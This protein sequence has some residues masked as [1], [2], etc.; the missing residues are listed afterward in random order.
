LQWPWLPDAIFSFLGLLLWRPLPLQY[1]RFFHARIAAHSATAMAGSPK[2]P[3]QKS[4]ASSSARTSAGAAQPLPGARAVPL[5]PHL[6]RGI[7]PHHELGRARS[8]QTP[9][10]DPEASHFCRAVRYSAHRARHRN[11]SPHPGIFPP[12]PKDRGGSSSSSLFPLSR[13][14]HCSGGSD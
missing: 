4:T 9:N 8:R 1:T 2:C 10:P 5:I 7:L 3:A 12:P 6:R 14:L 11:A 13:A